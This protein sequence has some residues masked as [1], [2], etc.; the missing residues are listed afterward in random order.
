MYNIIQRLSDNKCV[1]KCHFY[2][3]YIY[4]YIFMYV[5]YIYIYIYIYMYIFID[6]YIDR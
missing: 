5:I 2:V 3:I 1:L 6:R 4:I